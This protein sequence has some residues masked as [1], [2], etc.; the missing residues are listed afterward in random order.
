MSTAVNFEDD[1]YLKP[2]LENDAFLL[3]LDELLEESELRKNIP[4][5]K[6]DQEPDDRVTKLQSELAVV[7]AQYI[8]YRKKVEEVLDAQWNTNQ[9]VGSTTRN[10]RQ[11]GDVPKKVSCGLDDDYFNS[12]GYHGIHAPFNTSLDAY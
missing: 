2:V 4:R 8:N 11:H 10:D 1:K 5:V 3:S 7:K 12:Y 6:G 9:Q